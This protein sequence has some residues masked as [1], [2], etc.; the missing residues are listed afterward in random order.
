[1]VR[2]DD[3]FPHVAGPSI[4]PHI[5]GGRVSFHRVSV[6]IPTRGRLERLQR[7]L[8]SWDETVTDPSS[9][10]L[11]FRID[12]DDTESLRFLLK[13][14]HRVLVG[15]RLQGYRSLPQFFEEMRS[16]AQGDLLLTGNDDMVFRTVDW[17]QRVCEVA[18][19]H[20]DGVFCLGVNVQ[21]A[22][23]FP[24]AIVSAKA[25]EAI[26][27]LHDSRL[28][29]GDVF[30]RDVYAKFGRA[31]RTDA[32]TI[33]HE[34]AGH[35]K[36]QTFQEARQHEGRNWDERYWQRHHECVLDAVLKL[37][38]ALQIEAVA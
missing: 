34:W 6:L 28:F 19:Q 35:V 18:N 9:A 30:L 4:L 5:C 22:K 25:T 36:D 29:W 37:S 31:I 27:Y 20:P 1:M 38:V 16:K 8:A 33:D 15:Q 7:L 21:N 32:V 13:H 10:E 12:E 14:D 24:F 26:G 2:A 23:N 17:P 3:V 11:I